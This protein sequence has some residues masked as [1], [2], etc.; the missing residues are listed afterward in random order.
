MGVL[1]LGDV[2]ESTGTL[3]ARQEELKPRVY[4]TPRPMQA[5]SLA[6]VGQQPVTR[7][8]VREA[9]KTRPQT[10]QHTLVK[11]TTARDLFD[12]GGDEFM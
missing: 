10:H 8:S 5:W 9:A 7:T 3:A 11:Q 4:E 6:L 12:V 2:H 1:W